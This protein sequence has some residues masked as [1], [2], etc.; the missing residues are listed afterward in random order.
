MHLFE[1]KYGGEIHDCCE[2]VPYEKLETVYVLAENVHKAAKE[3]EHLF[4][5]H[6]PERAYLEIKVLA[7]DSGITTNLFT[8]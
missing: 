1:V 6:E 7:L 2:M 8:N 5:D 3:A 4:G